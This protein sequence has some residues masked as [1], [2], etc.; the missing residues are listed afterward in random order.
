M[1]IFD[2]LNRTPRLTE[3]EK[4]YGFGVKSLAFVGDTIV[5]KFDGERKKKATVHAIN[6][7]ITSPLSTGKFAWLS[8]VIK[9]TS[10]PESVVVKV[11][12]NKKKRKEFGFEIGK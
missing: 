5:Y 2:E 9:G 11:I 6:F 8:Y 10:I 12:R 7:L 1:D 4:Y 3:T